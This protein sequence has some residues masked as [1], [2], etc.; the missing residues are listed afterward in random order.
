MIFK[1]ATPVFEAEG[2]GGGGAAPPPAADPAASP[3]AVVPPT[4]DKG[5]GKTNWFSGF[6]TETQ[7]W[8]QNRGLD[9]L[10]DK[11]A[12]AEVIKG[13]R[14]LETRLGVPPDRLLKLPEKLEGDD[15]NAVY[16]RLGRPSK[17][18]EYGLQLK[19]EKSAPWVH[20][21]FYDAGVSK[22][23]A[24]KIAAEW[25]KQA[26]TFATEQQTKQ[27]QDNAL[28]AA[29][30]NKEWGAAKEY[31]TQIARQAAAEFGV[32]AETVTKLEQVLGYS[33]TMKFF[34]QIGEKLGEDSFVVG[35]VEKMGQR[36]SPAQAIARLADLK[37]DDAWR[38]R[39]LKGGQAETAEFRKLH[40]IAYPAQ[41][42]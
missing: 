33:K 39:Y 10:D 32:D 36:L 27:Q 1:F 34:N 19:D 7:G 37:N 21:M 2:T 31:K 42:G 15:M 5:G 24:E 28:D 30:L 8:V 14:N 16:D 22:A 38:G 25:T 20:K 13:H 18:E 17:P 9:K 41:Q 40:E 26:E 11:A 12:L 23:Q 4:D 29:S 3:A 6:D 35:G